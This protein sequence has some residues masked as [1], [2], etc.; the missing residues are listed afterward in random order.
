MSDM[1]WAH[2]WW[3]MHLD[4]A[5]H[6][7]KMCDDKKNS[8]CKNNNNNNKIKA[9]YKQDQKG[10]IRFWEHLVEIS[11]Y[12]S[13]WVKGNSQFMAWVDLWSASSEKFVWGPMWNKGIPNARQA[14]TAAAS[15]KC[16]LANWRLGIC[17]RAKDKS[18]Y[19]SRRLVEKLHWL[20]KA[21]IMGW[22]ASTLQ[23]AG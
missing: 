4:E 10:C 22:D 6:V 20:T 18:G 2:L 17:P 8:I 11:E 1:I 23:R 3:N 5:H 19:T 21:S 14:A 13:V 7:H 16:P 15:G 9:W 12:L